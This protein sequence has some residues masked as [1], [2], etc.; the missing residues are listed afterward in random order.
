MDVDSVY[1]PSSATVYS[2][3][4][5]DWREKKKRKEKKNVHSEKAPP[6]WPRGI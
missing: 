1:A 6:L 4:C 3:E 5:F 2:E